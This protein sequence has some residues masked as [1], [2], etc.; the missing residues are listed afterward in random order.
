M[1]LIDRG[2]DS[3]LRLMPQLWWLGLTS[4]H[5]ETVS[6]T[7]GRGATWSSGSVDP[8]PTR[9][10]VRD[11]HAAFDPP[12]FV[13]YSDFDPQFS[14][15]PAASA[16]SCCKYG[17]RLTSKTLHNAAY[18]PRFHWIFAT[19]LTSHG[20]RHAGAHFF[21]YFCR[22]IYGETSVRAAIS[23]TVSFTASTKRRVYLCDERRTVYT[24]LFVSVRFTRNWSETLALLGRGDDVVESASRRL[25]PWRMGAFYSFPLKSEPPILYVDSTRCTSFGQYTGLDLASHALRRK[26]LFWLHVGPGASTY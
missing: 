21:V 20:W 8:S 9:F 18:N 5:C 22:W 23:R 16:P 14:L 24:V 10:R 17:R 12:L 11:P 13:G 15:L 3:K 25:V 6:K 4:R 2:M 1:G 7:K 26:N 19:I